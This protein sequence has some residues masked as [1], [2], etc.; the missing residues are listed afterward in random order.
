MAKPD[1]FLSLL[2][3]IGFLPLRLPRADVAPLDMVEEDGKDLNLLGAM[4][5]AMVPAAGITAR[6]SYTIFK[7]RR[8]YKVPKH[9]R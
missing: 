3:D 6:R 2:K 1:P 8:T 9:H 4:T 5:N 7:L